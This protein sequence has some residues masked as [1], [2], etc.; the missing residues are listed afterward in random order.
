MLEH[1]FDPL[2]GT[3]CP[4]LKGQVTTQCHDCAGYSATCSDCFVGSHIR[5]PFHWAEVWDF[6]K[7]FFLRHDIAMLGHVIQLGHHGGPCPAPSNPLMFTIVH[8]NGVHS[9]KIAFC[10]PLSP[11][12]PLAHRVR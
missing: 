1:E 5:S 8:G 12:D 6:A 11:V 9:T 3:T 7:G 10:S 2:I 4:C